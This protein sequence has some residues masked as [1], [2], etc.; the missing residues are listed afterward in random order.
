[1]GRVG[2]SVVCTRDRSALAA[3]FRRDPLLHLYE[4]GDLDP[5]FWPSCRWYALTV[6]DGRLEAVVLEYACPL[7]PTVL[8]LGREDDEA[9]RT[10][11]EA[12][13]PAL[14][15]RFYAHLSP[16]LVEAL[17]GRRRERSGRPLKLALTDRARL[18]A[19]DVDGTASL[20]P[21]DLEEVQ[22]FFGRA[23]P[24]SWFD[25]RMLETGRYAGAREDG[26]L[27]AVAGVHV[28]SVEL[29]VAALGN[30]A[31]LPARRGRGLGRRVTAALCRRLVA[32]VEHVGLNVD[33]TN[34]AAIACY[35]RLGFTDVAPYEEWWVG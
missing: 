25:P 17:A 11:L 2:G 16:G 7:A 3:F 32:E 13:E 30:V 12:V 4:L 6:E 21:A 33:A 9:I 10:L 22:R 5:F 28:H 26:E 20:G 29:G 15:D 19:V 14:P 31:T 27:V 18:D 23:Y 24:D 34:A 1:M 8:A 35:R